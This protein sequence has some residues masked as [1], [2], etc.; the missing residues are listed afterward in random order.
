VQPLL[1]RHAKPGR[2][3]LDVVE[4]AAVTRRV[5]RCGVEHGLPEGPRIGEVLLEGVL[6]H[7]LPLAFVAITV[8]SPNKAQLAAGQL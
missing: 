2:Q 6:E 1:G 7:T 3:R 5:F 8:E 4:R